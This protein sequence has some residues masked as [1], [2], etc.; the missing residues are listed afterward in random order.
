MADSHKETAAAALATIV[1]LNSEEYAGSVDYMT[2]Y[3]Q[4]ALE[5]GRAVQALSP[6]D[7]QG[8]R[9][10]KS[11]MTLDQVEALVCKPSKEHKVTE[12]RQWQWTSAQSFSKCRSLQRHFRDANH[13]LRSLA[14]F[15]GK[16]ENAGA[17]SRKSILD[18]LNAVHAT[19]RRKAAPVVTTPGDGET[20]APT[21]TPEV[22]LTGDAGR[23]ANAAAAAQLLIDGGV[24]ILP[25]D[26]IKSLAVAVAENI[27]AR[28]ED[29]ERATAKS[30]TPNVK[31]G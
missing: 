21:E 2:Q 13:A 6:V 27:S 14:T 3:V 29:A 5:V 10:D 24:N 4:R 25:D 28:K 9:A 1:R 11:A 18:R 20:P 26:L 16:A 7:D 22:T 31:A 23:M 19:P 30:N 12:I 17:A 8:K 15:E